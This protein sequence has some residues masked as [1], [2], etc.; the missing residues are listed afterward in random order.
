M[1]KVRTGATRWDARQPSD[2]TR[3]ANTPAGNKDT[4]GLSV[5]E[6]TEPYQ[7]ARN[8]QSASEIPDFDLLTSRERQVLSL[9]AGGPSNRVIARKLGIAERTVK[10][11]LTN[12]MR[13]LGVES[14]LEA[15]LISNLHGK[16]L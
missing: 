14:R 1:T 3:P 6:N 11:H 2:S 5:Q 7:A 13:K 12:L 16:A 9:L 10:A 4:E 8:F 15:A